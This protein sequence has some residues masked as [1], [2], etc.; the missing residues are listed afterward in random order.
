MNKKQKTILATVLSSVLF[1]PM[2]VLG[3]SSTTGWS[4][5]NDY[6]L[7]GGT[8]TGIVSGVLDWLLGI[9]AILGVI[10]FVISGIIYLAS[11]G[12]DTAI[13][14]AKRAMLYSILGIVVGLSGFLIMYAIDTMLTGSSSTF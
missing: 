14:R 12:D 6:N 9:F 4:L 2:V 3:Y 1:L 8:I 13:E 5:N 11:A 7:P 10:G